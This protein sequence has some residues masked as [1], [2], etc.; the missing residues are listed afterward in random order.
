MRKLFAGVAVA[1][2]VQ[3]KNLPSPA[4]Q[5]DTQYKSIVHTHASDEGNGAMPARMGSSRRWKRVVR[6]KK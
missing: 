4:Y 3:I 6:I 2:P 1:L 5:D